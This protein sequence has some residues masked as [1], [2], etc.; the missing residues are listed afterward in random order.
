[1]AR[2]IREVVGVAL[3]LLLLTSAI[4]AAG[5]FCG[6][7]RG[8]RHGLAEGK[9]MERFGDCAWSQEGY[10]VYKKEVAS[11]AEDFVERQWFGYPDIPVMVD[12][13]DAEEMSDLSYIVWHVHK[14]WDVLFEM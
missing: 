6:F 12:E 7:N 11:G 9:C 5:R 1:M 8:F 4:F 14:G 13:D 2:R 3:T 10:G